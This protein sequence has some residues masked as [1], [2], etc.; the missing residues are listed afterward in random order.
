MSCYRLSKRAQVD[1]A[2]TWTYIGERSPAAADRLLDRINNA[3]RD[4]AASPEMGPRYEDL[5]GDLRFFPVR[6]YVIFYR[7]IAD[8]VEIVRVLHGARDFRAALE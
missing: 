8:G 6:K 7:P 3:F 1:L 5:P 4:L 2:D